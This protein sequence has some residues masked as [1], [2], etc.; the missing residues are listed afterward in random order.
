M[1]TSSKPLQKFTALTRNAKVRKYMKRC[2]ICF[3]VACSLLFLVLVSTLVVWA[4]QRPTFPFLKQ[5]QHVQLVEGQSLFINQSL[6]VGTDTTKASYFMWISD[7]H[8]ASVYQYPTAVV[9]EPKKL[10]VGN[11]LIALPSTL[12]P[13]NYTLNVSVQYRLNPIKVADMR[14]ELAKITVRPR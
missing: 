3:N 1:I 14:L 12:K 10:E 2:E 9:E 5:A 11:Q 7:E 4:A 6:V 13:G 8:G